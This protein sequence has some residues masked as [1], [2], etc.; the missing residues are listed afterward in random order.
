[1]RQV[2]VITLLR[3]P[4]QSAMNECR[5]EVE[6]SAD[7][8]RNKERSVGTATFSHSCDQLCSTILLRATLSLEYSI[9]I[10]FGLVSLFTCFVLVHSLMCSIP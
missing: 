2:L 7:V 1:M 4:S 6:S 9:D 5:P 8:A 3:R 10:P